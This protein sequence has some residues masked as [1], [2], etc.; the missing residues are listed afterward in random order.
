[1][2]LQS[3]GSFYDKSR[4]FSGF[5]KR[6][7]EW[8]EVTKFFENRCCYCGQTLDSDNSTED[9]LIPI[10]K[11]SLGLHAWGNIVPCCRHCNKEKHFNDWVDFVKT[12]C[13]SE[14][15]CTRR[16]NKIKEFQER[17][18]YN[19]NLKLKDVAQNLYEDV[20][21]VS[22]VLIKLRLEQAQKIIQR[23]LSSKDN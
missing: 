8:V 17:W 2:L 3:I 12:K 23:S 13:N 19:P 14:E 11:T 21:E 20:G 9:H 10:N 15:E 22:A 7:S 16:I 18:R 1:M 5:N 4:G 6:G